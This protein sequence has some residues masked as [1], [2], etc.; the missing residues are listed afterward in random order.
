MATWKADVFVN[1]TVGRITTEVEAA[2]FQGAKEQIYAKH[3]NVQQITNL[4]QVSRNSSSS[5]GDS[6]SGSVGGTVALIGLIAAGWAFMSFTPYVL[7]TVYG[8]G[9]T[10]ISQLLTGQSIE[11][12]AERSDD[13]GHG[14]AAIVLVLALLAGGFGFV[15]GSNLQKEWNTTDTPAEVKSK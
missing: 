14:K 15:Q 9:A 10:W 6:S 2:T 11:E 5:S 7:M 1:S 3:G 13:S 12:Y 8:A 4:H